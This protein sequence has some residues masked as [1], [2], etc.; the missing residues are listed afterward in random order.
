M[1]GRGI[2][3]MARCH[4]GRGGGKTAQHGGGEHL[5]HQAEVAVA[6]DDTV[7]VDRNAAALLPAV[8]QRIQGRIGGS[9]HVLGARPVID[10]ENAAFLV[11][12]I[13]KIRHWFSFFALKPSQSLLR[14][15]SSPE[16]GA[17]IPLSRQMA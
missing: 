15:A 17:F 6:L 2:A 4:V 7:I 5:V 9:G 12:R 16:G 13:C 14:N 10:A 3:D 8:L 11:Q 1:A